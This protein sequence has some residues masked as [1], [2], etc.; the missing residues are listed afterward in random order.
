MFLFASVVGLMAASGAVL[1]TNIDSEQ[2]EDTDEDAIASDKDTAP[3]EDPSNA[4]PEGTAEAEEPPDLLNQILLGDAGDNLTEGA[5]GDDQ[6]NGYGGDDRLTGGEGNDDLHGAEGRDLL[7]GGAGSDTLHG[8]DGD[9]TLQGGDGDDSLFGHFGQDL[10]QGGDGAD[11]IYGGQDADSL[12]GGPGNDALHGGY[13]DDTL[14]GGEG[15]DSLFGGQGDD[16]VI[17]TDDTDEEST[18]YLNGG[19]GADTIL[20]GSDDIVTSGAGADEIYVDSDIEQGDETGIMDFDPLEDRLVLVV[21]NPEETDAEITIEAD[22]DQDGLSHVLLDGVP[23]AMLLSKAAVD[24]G[25][26]L[27]VDTQNLRDILAGA[28]PSV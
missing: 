15:Q 23:V 13:D 7:L 20:A 6:I 24:P 28:A 18:D 8:Q 2:G 27:L 5:A 1:L 4:G 11:T 17:G 19:D 22:P 16:L 10:Q 12:E 21:E 3:E 14:T 26:I 25:D 9:D